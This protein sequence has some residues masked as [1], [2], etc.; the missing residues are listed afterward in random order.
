MKVIF[1]S[2]MYLFASTLVWGQKDTL[3]IKYDTY[4]VEEKQNNQMDTIVSKQ[5]NERNILF[6]T[7]VLPNTYQQ[8]IAKSY[9]LFLDSV[10]LNPCIQDFGI[11]DELKSQV[12]GVIQRKDSMSVEVNYIGNCC[13]SFLCDVEIQNDDSINLII[14]GYGDMYCTC[15]CCYGLKFHFTTMEFD[16]FK[17]LKFITINGNLN[18]KA[19][20]K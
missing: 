1:F 5:P 15:N 4:Q 20:L 8:Q 7:T 19:L 13:H 17:K 16:D 12:L 2:F 6:G 10:S 9:G 3:L 11:M 18:T 14:L